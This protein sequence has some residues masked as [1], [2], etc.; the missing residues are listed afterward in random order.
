MPDD[1]E[2][3]AR[4]VSLPQAKRTDRE[5]ANP[6]NQPGEYADDMRVNRFTPPPDPPVNEE[7]K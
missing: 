7:K 4:D 3:R 2:K 6:E 1:R 5:R